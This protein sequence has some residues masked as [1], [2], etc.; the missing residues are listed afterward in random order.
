M[1]LLFNGEEKLER[2]DFVIA[3]ADEKASWIFDHILIR[4]RLSAV[5]E[6]A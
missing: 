5:I 2:A 3:L 1:Q 6:Y 4:K